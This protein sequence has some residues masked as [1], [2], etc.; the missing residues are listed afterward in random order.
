M[1][2]MAL[3]MLPRAGAVMPVGDEGTGVGATIASAEAD[4]V[5]AAFAAVSTIL[6]SLQKEVRSLRGGG[7]RSS[8]TPDPHV[9]N[10]C[11]SG[12]GAVP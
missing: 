1:V 8:S 4:D 5:V 12:L 9:A 2:F 11:S 7:L 3:A 6:Y 10:V